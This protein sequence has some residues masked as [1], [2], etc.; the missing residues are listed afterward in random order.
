[1]DEQREKRGRRRK[2]KKRR[3]RGR[4]RERRQIEIWR[5]MERQTD[6]KKGKDTGCECSNEKRCTR[7]EGKWDEKR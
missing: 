3:E 1:M 5:R 4:R 6:R 2:G 7:R